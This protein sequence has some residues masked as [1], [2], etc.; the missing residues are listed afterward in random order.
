MKQTVL[1]LGLSAAVYGLI[2]F[3][4]SVNWR[5]PAQV[6]IP[7]VAVVPLGIGLVCRS[8]KQLLVPI[9]VWAVLAIAFVVRLPSDDFP[10][11]FLYVQML[12]IYWPGMTAAFILGRVLRRLADSHMWRARQPT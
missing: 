9:V 5:P 7:I 12:V 6:I 8:R 11:W 2:L 4:L 1:S 10:K 3:S